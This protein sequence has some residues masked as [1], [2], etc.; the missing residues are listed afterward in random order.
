MFAALMCYWGRVFSFMYLLRDS[1]PYSQ[2]QNLALKVILKIIASKEEK[3][4]L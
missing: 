2:L 4:G 3:K 1:I